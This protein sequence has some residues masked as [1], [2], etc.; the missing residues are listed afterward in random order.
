M[1]INEQQVE[2]STEALRASGLLHAA[3]AGWFLLR[4]YLYFGLLGGAAALAPAMSTA[5]LLLLACALALPVM[6]AIWHKATVRTLLSLAQ[7]Q[8]G[9]GLHWLGSRLVL[10]R[11]VG[12][13]TAL[14][15]SASA[16]IHASL[17]GVREW[18]FLAS[19]PLLFAAARWALD[20]WAGRQFR[21][22]AF[23]SRAVLS[24]SSWLIWVVI[25]GGWVWLAASHQQADAAGLLEQ[26]AKVQSTWASS[27]SALG[28]MAADAFAWG[29]AVG[30][31]STVLSKQSAWVLAIALVFAPTASVAFLSLCFR[32]LALPVSEFRR[33]FS[34]GP[35]AEDDP[36]PV[37]P[38]TAGTYAAVAVVAVVILAQLTAQA[39]HEAKAIGSPAAAV[40]LPDCD[41]IEGKV[42]K[43]GTADAVR[44]S[45]LKAVT[46]AGAEK[47]NICGNLDEALRAA[48]KPVDD[49][50]DWYFSLTAEWMRI[51]KMLNGELEQM[52]SEKLRQTLESEKSLAEALARVGQGT[53]AKA[54]I[55]ES[56]QEEV[57]A[58]LKDNVLVLDEQSCKVVN[59]FSVSATL[60]EQQAQALRL[61]TASSAG[62]GVAA[63]ALAA[64][65]A[66]KA[67]TK[68]S[69][70]AATKVLAKF[71]A[72]KAAAASLST[73]VGAAVGSVVPGL[74]TLVGAAV[75][76]VIGL[77]ISVAVDW[78]SL[79]A[80]EQL[81][82]GAMRAELLE[83]VAVALRPLREA[84]GCAP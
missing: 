58:L 76:T 7:F 8:P 35:S 33:V 42:Y 32:G 15:V 2:A 37:S 3:D 67:M 12:A 63:G 24:M 9:R 11:F 27:P 22:A 79:A 83:E 59:R 26:V 17:F 72:K 40:Q 13:V 23:Q 14:V 41:A 34:R 66:A 84:V 20:G 80:E 43:L 1:P 5:W 65:V 56:T 64:K 25:L 31:A 55:F 70:K 69:M 29:Q 82:R 78:A 21:G 81:T 74:G 28:R 52:L 18:L 39:E 19:A 46:L 68:S 51:W 48:H 47:T 10:S 30:D 45:L 36:E 71:A 77:S 61:R 75:G 60:Q 16:V 73:A 49:Y 4:A 50:L 38:L 62:A 57:Q 6:L 44:A 54:S 53:N